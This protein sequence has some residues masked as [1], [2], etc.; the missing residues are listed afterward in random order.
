ML[1]VCELFQNGVRGRK[2]N[3]LIDFLRDNIAQRFL[4]DSAAFDKMC[5]DIRSFVK[6]L[7]VRY[8]NNA[9]INF[10][11]HS[12][13]QERGVLRFFHTGKDISLAH[14]TVLV[15]KNYEKGGDHE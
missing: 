1:V 3:E 6:D 14:L 7:N 13:G 11:H 8:S 5:V 9:T 12:L 15:V 4:P 10:T 2:I